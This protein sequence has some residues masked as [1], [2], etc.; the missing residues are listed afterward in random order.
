[1]L[2]PAI[3]AYCIAF[4][5]TIKF[6][7]K[8]ADALLDELEALREKQRAAAQWDEARSTVK[9][10]ARMCYV[11]ALVQLICEVSLL[12]PALFLLVGFVTA[13]LGKRL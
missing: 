6:K 7:T 3:N 10:K 13:A 4:L 12:L 9:A 2:I 8:Q 11:W 5:S 1:M